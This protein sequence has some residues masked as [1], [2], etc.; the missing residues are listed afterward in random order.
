M[1]TNRIKTFIYILGIAMLCSNG[2]LRGQS[3]EAV[4]QSVEANNKELQASRQ[5]YDAQLLESK[6]EN[7]LPDPSVSY[8]HQYGN[9]AGLGI[10]GELIASQSF[11]F[12]TIYA[13][14]SRLTE[15]RKDVYTAQYT[16]NR[17][18]VLL[19]AKN[20]CMDLI[21][22]NQ[23]RSLLA[24]RRRNAEQLSEMYLRRMEKG[25]AN[26]LETN[27]IDLELLNA[28]TEERMNETDRIAKLNE[29]IA[30]NGGE[31]IDFRDSVYVS[32]SAPFTWEDLRVEALGADAELQSLQQQQLAAKRQV[33][34]SRLQ[35]LPD[36]EVGYR[37]N[38]ASGGER[39]N[40]FLVGM[41]IPLFSNR[42]QVKKAKVQT[43]Y[44]DLQLAQASTMAESRLI[45]LYHRL[46]TLQSAM[47]EYRRVLEGQ[48]NLALLNKALEAG[49]ISMIAY[50]V[51]V[52]TLYQSHDN[53]L[54]L[55]NEYQK[56]L[57]EL[58]RYKL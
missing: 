5:Y 39:F 1:K 11:E 17:Q 43:Q 14:R 2:S 28:K 31:R 9:R 3:V 45:Q 41:S 48:D 46:E 13:Q 58:Y 24:Q 18:R 8:T 21:W 37:L 42:N 49:E 47:D 30:L 53:Y 12:P 10:Q 57:A 38:T 29:L 19:S 16:Q 20:L 15:S 26:I 40:G 35:G 23:R 50:F 27:K 52:S 54:Q 25:D 44:V 51:N 36:L 34:V 7:N 4:L 56:V 55:Q 22:L 6:I 33:K 32:D